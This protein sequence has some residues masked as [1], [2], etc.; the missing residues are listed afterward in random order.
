MNELD[1]FKTLND[2]FMQQANNE[3]WEKIF[4]GILSIISIEGVRP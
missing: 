1:N 3:A 4:L 2:K